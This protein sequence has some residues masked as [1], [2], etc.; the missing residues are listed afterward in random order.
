M[1]EVEKLGHLAAIDYGYTA[2]AS[3]EFDGPKFLRITD[4]TSEGVDWQSVPQCPINEADLNKHKLEQN[5]I[6]FARTGATTGKSFLI[7]ETP[8][9]VAASYLIRLRL[10]DSRCLPEYVAL[11]F[12]TK[13]YWDEIERGISGSAQGG[14]NASKLKELLIPIPSLSEQKRI[15]AILDEAFGA[16][17]R[18][19]ENA[20]RN[21]A[22]ARELFDSY[23][24]R[25]FTEKCEG[26]EETTIGNICSSVEYGTSTKSQPTG[27][28]PV[29]RMG[30][31]QNREIDWTD[32]VYTD[33]SADIEKYILQKGDVLFNRTNSA[34]HVG[35]TCIYRGEQPAVFAG[36]LIRIHYDRGCVDG[37]FLNYY[38]NSDEARRHGKIVMSRSVNQ[39]NI[40]GKKLKDYR[41]PL[42]PIEDQKKIVASFNALRDETNSLEI[43]YK[44]KFTALDQLKQ[45]LLQ[46]A[47]TGQLT[48]K[49]KELE[50]V[51]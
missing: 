8:T 36:Y 16:I 44:Q 45:S 1:S 17:A 19:K 31:I 38:L 25:V 33:N 35:K 2:K 22:N 48:D 13:A 23:L 27:Q 21:L 24:N 34:E 30:N 41:F 29:L 50:L 49:T 43:L 28:V 46:K 5:D 20:A 39:A 10:N 18:A 7:K 37:E 9:A 51:I 47:F 11:Y 40:N 26:W 15:V 6:V 14:F 42:A 12:Q 4:L 32:L 3:F